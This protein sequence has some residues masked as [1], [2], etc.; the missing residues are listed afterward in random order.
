MAP[1][2]APGKTEKEEERQKTAPSI[3]LPKGGGAIR[4]MG[5]K[6]AANP[7]T[8]TGSM[9]VP[10][11]TSPGRS[12]FGPQ[13][14][15]SYD[16]GA[17][18]GPFGFG[19][20]L[21]FPAITRETEKG[22][23]QYRDAE[24][25]DV[26]ILPGAED[27]APVLVEKNGQWEREQLPRRKVA[28]KQYK[29]QRYRPRIEGLSAR[30]ELWSNQADDKDTFWRSI[31]K[32]NITTWY[33]KT[34]N[35]RILD[36]AAR[37]NIFSWLICQSYDDKGNVIVYRY[38]EEE[39]G[40]VDLIQAN[41]RNRTRNANRYLKRIYYGNREPYLPV[42]TDIQWPQPPDSNP[43][44]DPPNYYFKVVFDYDDGHYFEA[45]PDAEGRVY[46]QPVCSPPTSAQWST[47]VDPFSTYRAG[48]E[49]RT[50]R[51]CQRVL[52]F[53]HFPAELGTP[54]CLVRSMDFT[55]SYENDPKDARNPI[56]S[57]LDSVSQS[58][59]L[60]QRNRYLK[61]SLPPVEF[62]Y[63]KPEVQDAVE[64]VDPASLDNLPI[65]LDG[66]A[67]RWTDLHGEGIP[68]I[69]TEQAGAWYYKRNWSPIPTKLPDGSKVVKAKFDPL[70]TVALK[71]NV[72]LS[73][74]AE[75][76]DLAGDGQPDVVVMEGPTPG[77]YEHDEAEGWQPFRPFTSRLNHDTRDPN[78]K[79]IDLDGGGRLVLLLL[80]HDPLVARLCGLARIPA[81]RTVVA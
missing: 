58:G 41:E 35:S 48:F 72:A 14:S 40:N 53:H 32:D 31:S 70:E 17:G 66:S 54:D 8:G 63:T 79:F 69:L 20:S 80:A 25:S 1:N 67:Y 49:I 38:K 34:E 61:R 29:I 43:V 33:G 4:G 55:Y 60:R 50:H 37:A 73:G 39:S 45:A 64:L 68:G 27:L 18:N 7:V 65:G 2:S 6:F 75:F 23:P 74:G 12:G 5:E 56:Y 59:Y 36:P 30:I 10:I 57:F 62:G 47:R 77:L 3:S 9:T 11:A 16:S 52:M 42:L 22:L 44:S 76:M 13:L 81:D 24:E 15:L 71:P 51:L 78:L 19:W 26:F 46:A 28:G 21:S